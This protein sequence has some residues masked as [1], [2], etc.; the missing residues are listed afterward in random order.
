MGNLIHGLTAIVLIYSYIYYILE[1]ESLVQWSQEVNELVI[2]VLDEIMNLTSS[3]ASLSLPYS[4][5]RGCNKKE[6]ASVEL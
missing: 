5:M 1:T 4:I 2:T 3:P 6:L